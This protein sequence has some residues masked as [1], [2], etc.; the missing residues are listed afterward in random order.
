MSGPD[1][2]PSGLDFAPSARAL[3]TLRSGDG[4]RLSF[5]TMA[6]AQVG[7]IAV[8]AG[9]AVLENSVLVSTAKA[10][11][12]IGRRTVFGHR[13]VV[14]G[15]QVGDLC[16][17]G[18][19][20]IIM[21]GASLGDRVFTGEGTLITPGTQVASDSVVVGRPGR[22]IRTANDN[23]LVRL[24]SLRG[25]NLS[26]PESA[27]DLVGIPPAN[28]STSTTG[29]DMAPT[30]EYRGTS[31]TIASSAIVFESAEIFGDV[32]VGERTVIGAGV[33]ILGDSH[34]PVRI[35]DDVQI[36]E[37][38]VLHLLPDNELI[39]R[40]GVT[41]GPACMIHGCDIGEG[42]IIEPGAQVADWATVG[43]HCVVRAGSLVKQR[44]TF[45]DRAIIE[46]FPAKQIGEVDG[47]AGRPDWAVQ[48]PL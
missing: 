10:D 48:L 9:S 16:E 41:I 18:N 35:G 6:R 31:P 23:D 4:S 14:I 44:S 27:A 38:S 17:I 22:V 3:G 30:Y 11:V 32:V 43:K 39:V 45:G 37:N 13:C 46:G 26:L 47:E 34:G 20:T 1:F 2:A 24:K 12:A 8:G 21:P 15:A 29:A 5:G 7:A 25:G 42:S 36:L 19:G 33:R 28:T 40:D